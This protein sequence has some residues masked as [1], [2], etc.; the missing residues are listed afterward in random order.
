MSGFLRT[1]KQIRV[2]EFIRKERVQV[3]RYW[4]IWILIGILG[5]G[6]SF[7]DS[8]GTLTEM[9]RRFISLRPLKEGMS[10]KEVQAVLPSEVIIGYELT[11][12]GS[13][14]YRPIVINNPQRSESVTKGK[15][16][17][18]VDYYLLGIKTADGQITDEELVPLIYLNDKL[19][20]VGWTYFIKQVKN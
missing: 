9:S 5:Y 3:K 14:Q 10:K 15:K 13:E 4:L 6:M 16:N 11:D 1:G 18:A 12:T 7:E 19:A 8:S 20:G 2:T 17:Y